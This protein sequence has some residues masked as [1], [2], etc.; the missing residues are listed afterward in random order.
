MSNI[1]TF[2]QVLPVVERPIND[3]Q[4]DPM[5]ECQSDPHIL[6]NS[7]KDF[8]ALADIYW[9]C[10]F[11]RFFFTFLKLHDPPMTW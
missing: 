10:F 1:T 9:V 6:G 11:S 7:V 2:L 4:G 5:D 3:P 8:N